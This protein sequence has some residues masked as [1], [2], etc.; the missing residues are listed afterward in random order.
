MN[1][2]STHFSGAYGQKMEIKTH[3]Y[4]PKMIERM[5]RGPPFQ[6]N[7]SVHFINIHISSDK[8][9]H[10]TS[11]SYVLPI[12]AMRLRIMR[13]WIS[14]GSKLTMSMDFVYVFVKHF[15]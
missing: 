9:F 11:L 12:Y 2:K 3:T 10:I 15:E 13:V 8:S 5:I 4:H 1:A 6:S 7:E 14:A